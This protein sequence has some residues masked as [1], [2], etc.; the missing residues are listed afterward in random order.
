MTEIL[1]VDDHEI[2]R[3]GLSA[4]L[5]GPGTRVAAALGRGD[6]A[7]AFVTEQRVDVVVVDLRLPDMPGHELIR[8]LKQ[9]RPHVRVIVLSTYLSEE[10]VRQARE[11]GADEY[12]AK[13]AGMAELRAG[14]ER[15][16]TGTRLV[17]SPADLVRR[18]GRPD[19]LRLTPQQEK[20]LVLAASGATD[21]EIATTLFLSE[22]TVRFHLQRLKVLLG[23]RSKTQVIAEAFRRDLIRPE[24][25]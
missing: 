8:R 6:E 9:C 5:S 1:V 22:S 15:V 13:S 23:A 12:V 21:R 3:E 18:Q 25:L 2:V 4:S 17:E 10:S 19:T 24:P 16:V 7:I 11:A 20:V 14:L